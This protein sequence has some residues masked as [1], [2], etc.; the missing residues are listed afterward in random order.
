MHERANYYVILGL[1]PGVSDPAVIAAAIE[2]GRRRW[3]GESSKGSVAARRKAQLYL[4][5]LPE[6]KRV[7]SDASERREEADQ[8]RKLQD[9]QRQTR[10]RALDASIAVVRADGPASSRERAAQ[11]VKEFGESFSEAEILARIRA[12][13]VVIEEPPQK[14]PS[15][16]DAKPRLD[17]ARV[18]RLR[19]SLEVLGVENLY[20][21]LGM[22]PVSSPRALF[23]RADEMLKEILRI[24]HTDAKSTARKDLCGEA[25]VLFASDAEK[26]KYDSAL[27]VEP[28]EQLRP[29]IEMAGASGI[30]STDVQDVLLRQARELGVDA[31]AA[32]DYLDLYARKR[33]WRLQQAARLPSE[34]LRQCGY[35]FALE[36]DSRAQNCRRCGEPLVVACPRCDAT[37]PT[38]HAACTACGYRVGDAPVVKALLRDGKQRAI[39]G[40]FLAALALI[41]RAL[42]YWPGWQEA[43]EARGEVAS[44]RAARDA[45]LGE[46]EAL[47]RARKFVEGRAALARMRRAHGATGT[48]ALERQVTDALARAEALER[49]GDALR[50]AGRNDDAI[51]RYEQA[52]EHCAD[53]P[54]AHAAIAAFPPPP[55]SNLRAEPLRAGFRLAWKP[56]SARGAVRYAVVRGTK[57]RPRDRD[58]GA[59]VA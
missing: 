38:T 49:E 34:E 57:G 50:A 7:M 9:V 10:L 21:L 39:A 53:L 55:P 22:T 35:C 20:A 2:D 41:D 15:A 27:A 59:V 51:A 1:D 58:D 8:A 11:L 47:V 29:S 44:R 16:A 45:A 54:R 12:A 43:L 48:E 32:R 37:M 33:K 6:I 26:Q 4:E 56:S 42:L 28:M 14:T 46:I 5:Q 3:S 52:L 17:P 30:L 18:A 23:D 25:L 40:E 19:P 31:A 13:G 24:G 36:K